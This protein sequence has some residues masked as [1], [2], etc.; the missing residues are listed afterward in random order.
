[1]LRGRLPRARCAHVQGTATRSKG[2]VSE[3]DPAEVVRH[4][5][6]LAAVRTGGWRIA[7]V[8]AAPPLVTAIEEAN[9]IRREG[10]LIG[11]E[12]LLKI[13]LNKA[14]RRIILDRKAL[15]M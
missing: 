7:E 5:Q 1:M 10:L 3:I 6:A 11:V 9:D 8:G 14:Q 12:H 13:Q 2:A 4:G 15:V